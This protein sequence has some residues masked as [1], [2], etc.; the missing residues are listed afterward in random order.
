MFTKQVQNEQVYFVNPTNNSRLI[1]FSLGT[2]WQ[3]QFILIW[4]NIAYLWIYCVE[5]HRHGNT[6]RGIFVLKYWAC[7]G[8]HSSKVIIEFVGIKQ[9]SAGR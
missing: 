1:L 8:S 5:T 3:T 2:L 7:I 9:G 4:P 6:I